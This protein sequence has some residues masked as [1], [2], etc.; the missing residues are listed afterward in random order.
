VATEA[1]LRKI[2][3][4]VQAGALRGADQIGLRVGRLVNQY[5]VAKH[6]GPTPISWTVDDWGHNSMQGCPRRRRRPL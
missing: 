2:Q 5:K 4:R 1:N 3:R 6:F